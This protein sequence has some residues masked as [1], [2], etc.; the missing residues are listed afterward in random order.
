MPFPYFFGIKY[1]MSK[2]IFTPFSLVYLIDV[3]IYLYLP[4]IVG[5]RFCA[6]T[7]AVLDDT[8]WT[9]QTAATA[10]RPPHGRAKNSI[11]RIARQN[12]GSAYK[13]I[14]QQSFGQGVQQSCKELW[15]F[16]IDQKIC[17]Y[18]VRTTQLVSAFELPKIK[19]DMTCVK[20]VTFFWAGE[21]WNKS[22]KSL[23][24]LVLNGFMM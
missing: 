12:P 17:T 19:C 15:A 18:I 9:V 10:F 24:R 21:V 22:I 13:L 20:Y 16:W 5:F 6:N 3:K 4:R 2:C 1:K 14:E 23:K 8:L 11:A 7:N